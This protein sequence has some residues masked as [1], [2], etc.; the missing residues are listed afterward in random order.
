MPF[1]E[2]HFGVKNGVLLKSEIFEKKKKKYFG[3]ITIFRQVTVF[4]C[5]SFLGF[6]Y[7]ISDGYGGV[8][9]KI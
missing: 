9:S 5:I 6:A 1:S 4:G 3:H 8:L 7:V 2:I